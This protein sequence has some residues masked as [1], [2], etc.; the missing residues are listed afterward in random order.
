MDEI[1]EME[2]DS[3]LV[4][5]LKYVC[6][7]IA[8]INTRTFLRAANARLRLRSMRVG[9]EKNRVSYDIVLIQDCELS[10]YR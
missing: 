4:G 1:V 10:S 6:G 2:W 9:Y 7:S 3:G 5:Y 8:I